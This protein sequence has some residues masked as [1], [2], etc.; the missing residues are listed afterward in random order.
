MGSVMF[1]LEQKYSGLVAGV[2]EAGRGPLV[3]PVVAASVIIDQTKIIHGIKDSKKLTKTMRELLYKQITQNYTWSVGIVHHDEIDIINILEATKKACTISIANL[4]VKPDTVLIDGN[5]KFHDPRFISIINGDNLS[6]SIGAASIIAKVTRD[7]L[8]LEY[9]KE[10]PE[11]MWHKNSGYGTKE[12]LNAIN[13]HGLS[14]YHRKSF[15]IRS[16][17]L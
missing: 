4:A 17:T 10:F 3:G 2:D 7:R 13:L 16:S 11:Y 9:A 12:H 15:K 1:K 8:M 5:M 6:I 14:P